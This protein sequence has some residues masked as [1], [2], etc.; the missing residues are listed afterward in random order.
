MALAAPAS[1]AWRVA[2]TENFRIYSEGSEKTL[3]MRAERL[4]RFD[5]L[6]RRLTR[7]P[8]DRTMPPLT[9]YMTN[10]PAHLA[11]ATGVGRSIAGFYIANADGIAAFVSRS[12]RG[13]PTGDDILLHEY[14]HHFMMQHFPLAY[15][16]WYVEGFAEYFQT[17]DLDGDFIAYGVPSKMRTRALASFPW[18]PMDLVLKD[19]VGPLGDLGATMFYAQSWLLTHYLQRTETHAEKLPDYMELV[20]NGAAPVAAFEET[21]GIEV[22]TLE[23][24][25]RAYARKD[26][27]Y[28][29]IDVPDGFFETRIR[30]IERL[31]GSIDGLVIR[32]AALMA[33]VTG[34]KSE[35]ILAKLRRDAADAPDDEAL[36]RL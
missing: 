10:N 25:L 18:V 7:V 19:E 6:L 34:R 8:D 36:Q 2:E 14:V 17:A 12:A 22:D 11:D 33:G 30:T 13:G 16:R 9:V 28:S 32:H 4:E 31:P 20:A 24:V 35:T 21:F 26:M 3:T 1:A 27:S 23:R 5:L 15:P 29:R